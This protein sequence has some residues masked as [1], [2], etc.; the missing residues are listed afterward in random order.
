MLIY[1]VI[2]IPT[3]LF[4][5]KKFANGRFTN[6]RR[7]MTGKVVIITGASAGLGKETAFQLLH[8]GA[9]VIF[10]CRDELKTMKVI[11]SLAKKDLIKRAHFMKLD[12]TSFESVHKFSEEIMGN[13]LLFYSKRY[14]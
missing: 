8:D 4:L 5:I 6:L 1:L 12:L 7:D 9:D 10:A 11:N 3:L 13:W 14:I 2:L